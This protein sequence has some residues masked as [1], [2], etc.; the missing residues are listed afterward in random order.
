MSF[1]LL[2]THRPNRT[3]CNATESG[4]PF[5]DLSGITIQMVGI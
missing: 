1:K 3:I 4:R 2:S 5:R